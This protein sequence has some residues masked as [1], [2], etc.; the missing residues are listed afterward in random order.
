MPYNILFFTEFDALE[1]QGDK[2]FGPVNET[3]YQLKS[4]HHARAKILQNNE[5]PLCKEYAVCRGQVRI[6]ENATDPQNLLNIILRPTECDF[7]GIN[8]KY[9]IYRGVL[10]KSLAGADNKL[11]VTGSY[12]GPDKQYN[13]HFVTNDGQ[14][15]DETTESFIRNCMM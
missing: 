12:L 14:S 15:V 13:V 7:H 1:T 11:I 10:R 9:F 6:Q 3:Q 8:V 2:A 5:L 4:V